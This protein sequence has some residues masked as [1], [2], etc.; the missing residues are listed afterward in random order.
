VLAPRL[1]FGRYVVFSEAMLDAIAGCADSPASSTSKKVSGSG[2]ITLL[3]ENTDGVSP[4]R[5][6]LV[7][8][9]VKYADED[10]VEQL[11]EKLPP[12]F[13]LDFATAM[14]RKKCTIER[15]LRDVKDTVI[16]Y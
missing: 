2:P 4:S 8:I 14:T 13:V 15:E 10:V 7:D 1:D 11:G 3:Y 12:R 5:Q 16:Y 9:W 6:L